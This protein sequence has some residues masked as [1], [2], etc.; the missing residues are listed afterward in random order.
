MSVRQW[1]YH[2]LTNLLRRLYT[3][4]ESRQPDCSYIIGSVWMGG[5]GP[6]LII[7]VQPLHVLLQNDLSTS[8]RQAWRK[9]P[10]AI[11]PPSG[12]GFSHPPIPYFLRLC[13]HR[14]LSRLAYASKG[15]ARWGSRALGRG[16]TYVPLGSGSVHIQ[17]R[18]PY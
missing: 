13:V 17:G 12:A 15:A 2:R 1:S 6:L 7:D 11:I 10:L 14:T 16:G 5:A 3:R 9:H 18:L 4:L 8:P